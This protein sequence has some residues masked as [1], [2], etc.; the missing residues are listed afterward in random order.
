[1][2]D[3]ISGIMSE[4]TYNYLMEVIDKTNSY[5]NSDFRKEALNIIISSLVNGGMSNKQGNRLE[6]ISDYDY[7]VNCLLNSI[8]KL[9][10]SILTDNKIK[11]EQYLRMFI[12]PELTKGI[13]YKK[14]KKEK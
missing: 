8:R 9:Y 12:I 3:E 4:S 7:L 11:R 5:F 14:E 10:T 1:M 2:S 6:L 13:K